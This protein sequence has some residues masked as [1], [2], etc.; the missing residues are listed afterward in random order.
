M[1]AKA[2]WR[3]EPAN[4][5]VSVQSQS[6]LKLLWTAT[7]R[8]VLSE[9]WDFLT[10]DSA[11]EFCRF[12]KLVHS[13]LELTDEWWWTLFIFN[14]APM[15]HTLLRAKRVY[16]ESEQN[17]TSQKH[18]NTFFLLLIL[19]KS[20]RENLT[21]IWEIYV[22]AP[23]LKMHREIVKKNVSSLDVAQFTLQLVSLG[24]GLELAP[25]IAGWQ[26]FW[27][28]AKLE[29]RCEWVISVIW[30][31]AVSK[32]WYRTGSAVMMAT[33]GTWDHKLVSR[34]IFQAV[35]VI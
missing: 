33:S 9:T 14:F 25:G 17:E 35:D 26:R 7:H 27:M 13:N 34:T 1:R 22:A 24:Q 5:N 4:E 3:S 20:E 2:K 19:H 29:K 15:T 10:S 8:R 11:A 6:Q 18:R 30:F 21:W 31:S 23:R 32:V 12:D 16:E 28:W